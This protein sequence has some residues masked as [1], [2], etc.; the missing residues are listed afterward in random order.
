MS[1]WKL[2]DGQKMIA[3]IRTT[4]EL[5]KV[6]F[7]MQQKLESKNL[8]VF[9]SHPEGQ[10]MHIGLSK[11]LGFLNY[12]NTLDEPPYYSTV[13]DKSLTLDDGVV[14]FYI[15]GYLSEIPLRNC[16]SF[17]KLLTAVKDFF[18]TGNLSNSI[19]WEED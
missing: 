6:L 15:N 5:E 11:D 10:F 2:E 13:G 19:E 7:E 8:I 17:E 3:E 18:R 14:E 9:L 1:L 16:I 4:E 12:H